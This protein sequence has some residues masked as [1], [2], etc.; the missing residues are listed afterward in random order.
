MKKFLSVFFSLAFLL[1]FSMPVSASES[2]DP[3]ILANDDMPSEAEALA[4]W[5]YLDAS[6]FGDEAVLSDTVSPEF[7][8]DVKSACLIEAETGTILYEYNK[9]DR[10]MPASVTKVMTLLL[11]FEAIDS[12]KISFEDTVTASEH[13]ASMGGTQ[14]YLKVGETMSVEDLVKAVVVPS[15]NDAAVALAEFVAGSEE[16]FVRQMNERAKEL[17]MENTNF[18][19]STGLFDDE[20]HYTSA[21][22][23][24]IASRELIKHEKIFDFS[25]IWMDTLRDGQFSL[26]NTNKMLKTYAGMKGLKTGY[27]RASLHSFSGVAERNGMTLI[28]TIMGGATSD[29]RFSAAASLLNFGFSNFCVA[30]AGEITLPQLKVNK[31]KIENISVTSDTDFSLVVPKG[32]DKELTYEI[33]LNDSVTAPMQ[34]GEQVGVITYKLKDETVKT[35]PIVLSEDVEKASVWDYFT[36]MLETLFG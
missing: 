32:W 12:G 23:I 34:K 16:E 29:I 30:K 20:N 5:D 3:G 9:D 25:T 10:Y 19:N 18:T 11:V 1:S 35:C 31:G 14:I 24:A 6:R 7:D 28:V 2:A 4:L 17:G 33:S 36:S 27:T 8:F 15:A 21:A 26:A 13:A 22:D